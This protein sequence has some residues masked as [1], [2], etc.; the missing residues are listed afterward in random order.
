MAF[1]YGGSSMDKNKHKKSAEEIKK[2]LKK[3]GAVELRGS[4]KKEAL[5]KIDGYRKDSESV[6]Q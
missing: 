2:Y 6:N 3:I 4:E 1:M 5:K